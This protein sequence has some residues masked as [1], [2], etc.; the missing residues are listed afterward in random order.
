MSQVQSLAIHDSVLG[1][2]ATDEVR[3]QPFDDITWQESAWIY[4]GDGKGL[5][6][7]V[8][9]GQEMNAG[10]ANIFASAYS[11]NLAFRRCHLGYPLDNGPGSEKRHVAGPYAMESVNG[12]TII[13]MED[14]GVSLELLCEDFAPYPSLLP[15]QAALGD[16]TITRRPMHYQTPG[17]VRGTMKLGSE[18]HQIDGV[19]TRGHS[20]GVRDFNVLRGGGSRVAMGSF[21]PEFSYWVRVQIEEDGNILRHG[22]VLENDR[23]TYVD[24]IDLLLEQDSDSITYRSGRILIG[25]PDGQRHELVVPFDNINHFQYHAEVGIT[26]GVMIQ[27]ERQGGYCAWEILDRPPLR[28]G[29]VPPS[30]GALVL[31][32]LQLPRHARA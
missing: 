11:S 26:L 2:E 13:R 15:V 7:A 16:P 31:D 32:G 5:G 22:Y 8:H 3:H 28:P 14:E 30:M 21:G 23:L 1:Y 4:W 24:D 6:G 12:K 10:T 19:A 18:V 27:D 17:R 29:T 9:I 25:M 20:W